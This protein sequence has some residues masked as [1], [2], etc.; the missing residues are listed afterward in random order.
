MTKSMSEA[1]STFPPWKTE[2]TE[3]AFETH[4]T[5]G[6]LRQLNLQLL[7]RAHVHHQDQA[8]HKIQDMRERVRAFQGLK[9]DAQARRYDM[10]KNVAIEKH[11]LS[12]QVTK[13]RD[14]PPEKMN[15]LLEHMG[16]PP[17]KMGKEEAEEEEKK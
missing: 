5:M 10:M 6:E 12:F 14:A 11:H 3:R 1:Y 16:L 4:K 9:D 2:G 13:V 15:S 8:L 17:V 7:R